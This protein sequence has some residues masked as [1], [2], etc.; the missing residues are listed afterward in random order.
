[1]LVDSCVPDLFENLFD[2]NAIRASKIRKHGPVNPWPDSYKIIR[3]STLRTGYSQLA[4]IRC[5]RTWKGKWRINARRRITEISSETE[6]SQPDFD[7]SCWA[8]TT[9]RPFDRFEQESLQSTTTARPYDRFEQESLQPKADFDYHVSPRRTLLTFPP[10]LM[11]LFSTWQLYR[12]KRRTSHR[13]G[14]LKTVN[15]N[16]FVP[17]ESL[18]RNQED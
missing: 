8:T 16:G 11:Q 12:P 3:S 5:D 9:A 13:N 4:L 10:V 14:G 15:R 6:T 1:M 7:W 18:A 2:G 17:L